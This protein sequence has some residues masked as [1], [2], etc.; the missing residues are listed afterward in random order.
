MDRRTFLRKTAFTT[1]SV[2]F[3]SSILEKLFAMEIKEYSGDIPQRVLGKTKE[4]V[5]IIGLGGYHIG[6]I[7]DKNM[8]I[9]MI[10]IAFD[11]GINFFDTAYSYKH[12]ESEI[13]YGE[14]FKKFGFRDKVFLMS[15]STQRKADGAREELETT[16][17]RLQTDYLDLWQIHSIKTEN[18]LEQIFSP[19][20]I[21]ETALKAKK[22]GKIR[23]IGITGHYDPYVNL[24]ALEHHQLLDTIQ[25]PINFVDPNDRSF[26]NIVL[27]TAL[28][29]NLGIIAMKTLANGRITA[30]NIADPKKALSYV[31]NL[32]VSLLVSGCDTPQ[33]LKENIATSKAYIKMSE[34]EKNTF[35]R[36]MG[37][38]DYKKIEYYKK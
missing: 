25:M 23:Y 2:G 37:K 27:P 24:K 38:V 26:I 28:K 35:V 32:P 6:S 1:V 12:G 7:T 3:T 34:N 14:A 9:D 21:Y 13:R 18:D 22:E 15:K 31:W 17:K 19:D 4:K 8:A 11:S 5:S 30:N 10:K 33:Q 36:K 20:G 29:H 16:L